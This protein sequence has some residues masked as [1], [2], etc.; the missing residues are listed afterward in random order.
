MQRTT[1]GKLVKGYIPPISKGFWEV[2]FLAALILFG[3]CKRSDFSTN[4][5]PQ[6]KIEVTNKVRKKLNIR[7]IKKDWVFYGRQFRAEDWKDSTGRTFKRVQHNHT[8][9][10]IL[11]EQDYYYSGRTIPSQDRDSGPL[12]EMLTI[13]FNYKSNRFYVVVT[14]DSDAIKGMEQ[15]L[16]ENTPATPEGGEVLPGFTGKTNEETLE[17]VDKILKM[18]GLQRL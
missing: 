10:T 14:T 6:E 17:V 15:Y 12:L 13:T 2:I 3:G 8:Y 16:E 7:Q 9:E 5:P 18:W 4:P 1:K 11:W